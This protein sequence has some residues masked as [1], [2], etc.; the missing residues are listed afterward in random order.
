M[1]V[2]IT[3]P[4][5]SGK[6][7]VADILSREYGFQQLAFADAL[8][9]SIVS[10][11]PLLNIEGRLERLSDVVE[12]ETMDVAKN[13]Y[14]QVRKILQ[15]YGV[16]MRD[17]VDVDVW[18][19][20]LHQ[21]VVGGSS[22]NICITDLRFENELRYV[23]DMNGVVIRVERP[24]NPFDIG[25]AHVS[26]QM[27]VDTPYVIVNHG[28]AIGALEATVVDCWSEWDFSHG[29]QKRYVANG[30]ANCKSCGEWRPV[31][32]FPPDKRMSSGILS[33]CRICV[34]EKAK[35]K[36]SR[37][38]EARAREYAKLDKELLFK[39]SREKKLAS[40]GLTVGDYDSMLD[41][42]GGVC[43]ICNRPENR[44]HH[45]TGKTFSL[46]VDHDHETGKVRGLLCTR[47]NKAIGALGD[48]HESI[49]RAVKYLTGWTE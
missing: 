32:D 3:G 48:S 38:S 34:N 37:S 40:Y 44:T 8:K 29:Y 5:G 9:E 19:K 27:V 26:E 41:R 24:D 22:A 43:A 33:R 25:S 49:A 47:C 12:R 17:V 18:I 23:M 2:G 13:K 15:D 36:P 31:N 46:A 30:R 6:N 20:A 7:T 28:Y 39:A 42:Q 1:I 10:L 45:L 4:A 16:S 14:P 35:G 11:D 21:R